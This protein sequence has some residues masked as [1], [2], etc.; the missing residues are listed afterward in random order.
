MASYIFGGTNFL[1]GVAGVS[2]HPISAVT[3]PLT[4][5]GTAATPAQ[6]SIQQSAFAPVLA[7]ILPSAPPAA[8]LRGS[9]PDTPSHVAPIMY[10][11]VPTRPPVGGQSDLYAHILNGFG[12]GIVGTGGGY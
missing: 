4:Q 9:S 10:A 6:P 12:V 1:H 7:A 11:P 2:F 8:T 5:H 3:H